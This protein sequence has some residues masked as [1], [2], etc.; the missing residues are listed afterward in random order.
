MY[1]GLIRF[2]VKQMYKYLFVYLFQFKWN[3]AV[4]ILQTPCL[5]FRKINIKAR[6][7]I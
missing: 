7:I 6:S 1:C 4:L 2:G 3:V 5:H